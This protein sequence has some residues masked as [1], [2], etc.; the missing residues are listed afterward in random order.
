MQVVRRES[1]YGTNTTPPLDKNGK[2]INTSIGL[3]QA[4]EGWWKQY[5]SGHSL[6]ERTDDAL[7]M[8]MLAK[9]I[10]DAMNGLNTINHRRLTIDQAIASFHIGMTGEEKAIRG[11]K[12]YTEE[13]NKYLNLV[14]KG[15]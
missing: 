5:A 1:T 9:Y 13:G 14:K 10:S 11:D 4:Q 7:A 3:I 2:P 15:I 6:D 12:R 8:D